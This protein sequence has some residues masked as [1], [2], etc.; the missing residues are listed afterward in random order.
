MQ[1]LYA[2]LPSCNVSSTLHKISNRSTQKNLLYIIK[3][4]SMVCLS[5][6]SKRS[7]GTS[8]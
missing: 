1:M 7:T 3:C 8:Y 5:D 4:K 6:V 2:W